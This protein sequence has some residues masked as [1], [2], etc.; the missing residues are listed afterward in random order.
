MIAV[1]KI[2]T[3]KIA[4]VAKKDKIG[5]SPGKNQEIRLWPGIVLLFRDLRV[6][7][8]PGCDVKGKTPIHRSF[9]CAFAGLFYFLRTQRHARVHV[10]A[11]I[12]VFAAAAWVHAS[13]PDWAILILTVGMVLSAEAVNT[14]IEAVVDLA[15]P[16]THPIA[17]IAKDVAAA[18][19][20]IAAI[21]ATAVGGLIL[22][23]LLWARF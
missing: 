9:A 11:G 18:A 20:L 3:A 16:E 10:A 12:V 2:F 6:G 19:V 21:A 8:W 5:N 13:R 22:G 4:K 14:A 23:P 17:R 7:R 15:S 1:K